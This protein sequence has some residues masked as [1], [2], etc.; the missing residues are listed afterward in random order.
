MATESSMSEEERA[1]LLETVRALVAGK[2]EPNGRMIDEEAR[3]SPEVYRSL[4]DSGMH[5]STIPSVYGGGGASVADAVLLV[6]EVAKGS[7]AVASILAMNLAGVAAIAASSNEQVKSRLLPEVSR[8]EKLL[9]WS[10]DPSESHGGIVASISSEGVLL[11]GTAHWIPCYEVGAARVVLLEVEI[12]RGSYLLAVEVDD[13]KSGQVELGSL[14]SDLGLR[15]AP[16]RSVTFQNM[17]VDQEAMIVA[18]V[19]GGRASR[20]LSSVGQIA[21]AAQANVIG[22]SALSHAR[23]YAAERHQFGVPIMDFEST[24]TIL[25]TMAVNL[26]A[27]R[28]LTY[29]AADRFDRKDGASTDETL[30]ELSAKWF[31][32]KMAVEVAIDAIQVFGGY[33]FVKD[34]PVERL[35][36]DAKMTQLM[37]G[38]GQIIAI[39]DA[40]GKAL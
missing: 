32:S 31:S 36:R 21:I 9:V 1:L 28:Q 33:G 18:G 12:K 39:A 7:G 38:T 26:E 37:M 19:P 3:I 4:V 15:G 16:L 29:A 14:E 20:A 17:L 27:A 23:S 10:A 13:A 22:A 24:R 11:N 8:G 5:A 2:I 6:E 35:M 34:Y 25:G 30:L 40:V